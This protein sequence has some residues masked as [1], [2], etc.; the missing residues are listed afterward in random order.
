MLPSQYLL[1]ICTEKNFRFDFIA[2]YPF[3]VS[4][5]LL[6]FYLLTFHDFVPPWTPYLHP[7]CPY[8]ASH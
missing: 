7:I 8:L 6:F 5:K 4:I 3:F 2:C 1:G